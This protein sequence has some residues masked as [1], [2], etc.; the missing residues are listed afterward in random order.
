M[1]EQDLGCCC[2]LCLRVLLEPDAFE[3][4]F[5]LQESDPEVK[6]VVW[7]ACDVLSWGLIIGPESYLKSSG[8]PRS[9]QLLLEIA[10]I[11]TPVFEPCL[12]IVGE[13]LILL[14]C[15]EPVRFFLC[16]LV[17]FLELLSKTLLNRLGI[18]HIIGHLGSFILSCF[19]WEWDWIG[20]VT[21]VIIPL[22]L[23]ILILLFEFCIDLGVDVIAHLLSK[24]TDNMLQKARL[25]QKLVD[26]RALVRLGLEHHLNQA[27]NV[28]SDVA[29][30]WAVLSLIN[31]LHKTH[32]VSLEWQL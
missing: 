5:L 17:C 12:L 29:G 3:F 8:L 7:D 1:A 10:F 30:H 24:L 26:G 15:I 2:D 13:R 21:H 31:G 18:D 20:S 4:E 11:F 9:S 25:V 28:L 23:Q 16:N 6:Q 14:R 19:L 32:W 27:F 22:P